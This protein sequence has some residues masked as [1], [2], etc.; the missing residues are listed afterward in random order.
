[1]SNLSESATLLIEHFGEKNSTRAQDEQDMRAVASV[2]D[3]MKQIPVDY[4][5]LSRE[6]PDHHI[7]DPRPELSST[8]IHEFHDM[9]ESQ[10]EDF[11]MQVIMTWMFVQSAQKLSEL[12]AENKRLERLFGT[13]PA[14]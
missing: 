1:M 7:T 5:L 2:I 6:N 10:K 4:D 8:F 13:E 11:R 9:D 14:L 3:Y 12:T